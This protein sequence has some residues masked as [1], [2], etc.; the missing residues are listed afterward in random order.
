MT[1]LR[2]SEVALLAQR[3]LCLQVFKLKVARL[4]SFTIISTVGVG[5]DYAKKRSLFDTVKQNCFQSGPDLPYD[6]MLGA[7]RLDGKTFYGLFLCLA[8]N[9]ANIRRKLFFVFTYVWQKNAANVLKVPGAP[10][11]VNPSLFPIFSN[12]L[13]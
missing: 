2:E 6:I 4:N 9:V 3:L 10:R 7:P 12:I 1:E 11:T 5:F 13:A 8:E